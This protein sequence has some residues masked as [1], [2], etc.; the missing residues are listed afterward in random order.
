M[1]RLFQYP[2]WFFFMAVVLAMCVPSLS[3][4]QQAQGEP[5]PGSAAPL[6]PELHETVTR[7]EEIARDGDCKKAAGY[8]AAFLDSHPEPPHA[9]VYYDLGFFHHSAG[10][11]AAAAPQL[12]TAVKLSPCFHEAWQLLGIVRYSQKDTKGAAQAMER[13]ATLTGDPDTTYQA[14]VFRLEANQ[15]E[16][17]L[18]LLQVLEQYDAPKPEWLV[19]LSSALGALDKKLETAQA[20]ERAARRGNSP[21]LLFQAAWLWLDADRPGNALGLLQALAQRETPELDWLLLLCN[22]CMMLE[23]NLDAARVMDRVIERDPAPDHLYTGGLLWLQVE[24]SSRALP[25]LLQ[26]TRLPS[27][28]ADWFVALCQAWLQADSIPEAAHAMEQAF[29]ISRKPEHAFQAGVMRLQLEQP[30]NALKLLEPLGLYPEPQADWLVALSNAWSM[31]EVFVNA[32][33]AMERAAALSCKDH[34]LFLAAQ[35]WLQAENPGNAL[36]LLTRLAASPTP[37]AAWLLTL[38]STF[39]MLD[40]IP[41]AAAVME[42]AAG[43]TGKGKHYHHAGMLWQQADN[44]EKAVV[45]LEAC[46]RTRPVLPQWRVD[47]ASLLTELDRQSR[48]RSVL[49]ETSLMDPEVA[50]GLRYRGAVLWVTLDRTEKALPLLEQL[51]KRPHP[52]YRWLVS[53][54]AAA[55][56]LDRLPQAE[57]V[58]RQLLDCYPEQPGAWKLATRVAREQGD[59]TRAAAATDVAVRLDP[60]DAAQARALSRY[61]HMAGV[62]V[63]AGKAFMASLG[64]HPVPGDWDRLRDI[65]LSGHRC[66]LALEPARKALSEEETP[67]RWE[68]VGDIL[69]LLYR[70]QE[71]AEAYLHGAELSGSSALYLK[72]GYAFMKLEKY[73]QAALHFQAAL[74]QPGAADPSVKEAVQG[75]AYIRGMKAQME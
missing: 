72:T 32:A 68:A 63:Q 29:A 60:S 74:D 66:D 65:Y 44:R 19:A 61:Y 30:D 52:D 54:V 70:Y 15:P 3:S 6:P 31:K 16:K 34:H 50:P 73:D 67:D 58:L 59:Y 23:K 10:D 62:P 51:C 41:E 2:G 12:E 38:A 35:L 71:S 14:A 9:Y 37:E 69:F 53:L 27:P 24:N 55:V 40:R 4:G 26:L 45:L 11:G 22:T 57:T 7:A 25:H 36:P 17:A 13:A 42:R 39:Q 49:S 1:R 47:L 75:L 5:C 48:A 64:P 20:M 8:L 46:I 56:E 43:I 33:Q 21:Q 28:E 18:P